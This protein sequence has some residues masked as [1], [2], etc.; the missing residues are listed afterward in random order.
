MPPAVSSPVPASANPPP[1]SPFGVV[2]LPDLLHNAADKVPGA[3]RDAASVAS[4]AAAEAMEGNVNLSLLGLD[5]GLD[6]G[7]NAI[8]GPSI[9]LLVTLAI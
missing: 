8:G 1:A 3:L 9:A 7:L 6:V 5:L 2:T 4:K